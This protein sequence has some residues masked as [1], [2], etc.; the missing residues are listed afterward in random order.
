M[1]SLVRAISLECMLAFV[2]ELGIKIET[3]TI[4]GFVIIILQSALTLILALVISI[5]ALLSIFGKSAR[6]RRRQERGRRESK[7][8][9]FEF[10]EF[11]HSAPTNKNH[12]FYQTNQNGYSHTKNR[13]C[14]N[15]NAKPE[16]QDF[17]TNPRTGNPLLHSGRYARSLPKA[18]TK[19]IMQTNTSVS[20]D[21]NQ[22]QS[23]CHS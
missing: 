17:I 5:S 11:L 19:P 15:E 4:V 18:C 23:N 14:R 7:L 21:K 12:L 1:I 13:K 10:I 22:I 3:T 16:Y 20:L 8:P 9:G 6:K 2:E